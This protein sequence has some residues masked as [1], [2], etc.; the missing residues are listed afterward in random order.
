MNAFSADL[1]TGGLT[2]LRADSM[3][4]HISP[5]A[6]SDALPPTVTARGQYSVEAMGR[7]YARRRIADV[8]DANHQLRREFG[9]VVGVST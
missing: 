8:L 3:L 7:Q 5:H 1:T 2:K 4:I 9:L 6:N